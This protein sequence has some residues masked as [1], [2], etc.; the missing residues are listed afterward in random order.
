[1]GL[2]LR[3]ADVEEIG[4]HSSILLLRCPMNSPLA[5]DRPP[6]QESDILVSDLLPSEDPE[7][8]TPITELFGRAQPTGQ[9]IQSKGESIDTPPAPFRSSVGPHP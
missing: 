7:A 2:A 9:G 3:G 6:G 4:R 1:M 8:E 5:A